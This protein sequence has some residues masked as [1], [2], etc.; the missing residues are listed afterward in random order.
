MVTGST[1]IAETKAVQARAAAT[2]QKIIQTATDM[3]LE[4]GYGNTEARR[5]HRGGQVRSPSA[6][7]CAKAIRRQHFQRVICEFPALPTPQY[8]GLAHLW[9]RPEYGGALNIDH[10]DV[11]V[12][13][14]VK[15]GAVGTDRHPIW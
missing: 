1:V 5:H 6:V 3:F 7:F 11:V 9:T 2:R 8:A 10:V 15:L 14:D 12:V 4:V 13:G